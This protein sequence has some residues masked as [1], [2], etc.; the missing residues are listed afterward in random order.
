LP[1]F[2]HYIK[3]VYTNYKLWKYEIWYPD[4]YAYSFD[5]EK[6][7]ISGLRISAGGT[8]GNPLENELI[9][10]CAPTLAGLKAASL[11]RFVFPLNENLF[12]SIHSLT[13]VLRSKN[14][15][16]E[17]LHL[18]VIRRS[19]LLFVHRPLALDRIMEDHRN[20]EF[21]RHQGY[22]GSTWQEIIN[23]MANRLALRASFPHEIGILL[24]Y[25]LEDVKAYMAAP[26]E[27]GLCSGCW[28]AYTHPV[29]ARH[30]FEKCQKCTRIYCHCYESGIPLSRLAVA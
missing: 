23:E 13:C 7:A 9:R 15:D 27:K 24:D 21:F 17:L 28:K 3:L 4:H 18:D 10:Q 8:M 1:L 16:M 25:P 19:G 2:F 6:A 12:Q 20:R 11:F 26:K 14:L 22:S 29:R 5:G 30:F